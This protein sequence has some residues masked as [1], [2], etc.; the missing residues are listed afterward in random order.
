MW[1]WRA[2]QNSQ[3]GKRTVLRDCNWLKGTYGL[4]R[5]LK[6]S[7]GMRLIKRQKAVS[8]DCH[9]SG[10]NAPCELLRIHKPDLSMRLLK[11]QSREIIH[12]WIQFGSTHDVEVSASRNIISSSACSYTE[13]VTGF[14]E[15][16]PVVRM[17]IVEVTG[18]HGLVRLHKPD[19]GMKLENGYFSRLVK[20]DHGTVHCCKKT[21]SHMIIFGWM[22]MGK[23]DKN[24]SCQALKPGDQDTL[25]SAHVATIRD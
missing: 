8:W 20:H 23:S 12:G 4:L 10:G 7:Q 1:R 16:R 24:T 13:I 18:H 19:K 3:T 17:K 2:P 5:L 6:C 25:R 15:G 9:G 21:Q 14:W 22:C 11:G